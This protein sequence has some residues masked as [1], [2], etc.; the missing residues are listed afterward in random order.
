MA[1]LEVMLDVPDA[2]RDDDV[3]TAE[4]IARMLVRLGIPSVPGT[5]LVSANWMTAR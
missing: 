5:Q 1:L 4:D 2:M 3:A